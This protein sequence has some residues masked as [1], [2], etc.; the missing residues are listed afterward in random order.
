MSLPMFF[1]GNRGGYVPMIIIKNE[2]KS[3]RNVEHSR[4]IRISR[5][6]T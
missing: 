5:K 4:Q 1:N 2:Y 3:C 6:N